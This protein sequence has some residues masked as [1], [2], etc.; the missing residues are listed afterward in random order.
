MM[1]NHID[2][3]EIQEMIEVQEIPEMIEVNLQL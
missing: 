2:L 1:K 3:S